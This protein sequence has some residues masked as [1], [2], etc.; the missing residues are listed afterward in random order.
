LKAKHII[1]LS[2]AIITAIATIV[3]AIIS[4]GSSVNNIFNNNIITTNTDNS[5]KNSGNTFINSTNINT[6]TIEGGISNSQG[7][8]GSSASLL[9]P[10]VSTTGYAVDA[11]KASTKDLFPTKTQTGNNFEVSGNDYD[12]TIGEIRNSSR[13]STPEKLLKLAETEG[14][15]EYSKRTYAGPSILYY[16]RYHALP[17]IVK[18]NSTDSAK[19]YYDSQIRMIK[20]TL[21]SESMVRINSPMTEC[22]GTSGVSQLGAELKTNNAY[23]HKEN[24]FFNV[25]YGWL[26]DL[27]EE[28]KHTLKEATS[29][30]INLVSNFPQM[31]AT[32]IANAS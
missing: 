6:N 26:S 31:I 5:I 12:Y 30:E 14:F 24:F 32:N 8:A 17:E 23:C 21:H 15:L 22:F 27:S 28:D 19:A 11:I 29:E 18:F 3:A 10:S 9:T 2:A 25:E 13:L 4:Q 1:I 7:A 20:D 16:P